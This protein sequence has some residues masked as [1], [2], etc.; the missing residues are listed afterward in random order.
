MLRQYLCA[1]VVAVLVLPGDPLCARSEPGEKSLAPAED[2]AASVLVQALDSR[3]RAVVVDALSRNPAL[4]ALAADARAAFQA[5]P[6]VKALP[7]PTLGVTAFLAP[8][9][10]RV[11]PQRFMVSF[12]QVLPAGGKR[13][14][15]EVASIHR[16]VALSSL[17]EAERLR[18][19]TRLRVSS[20]ELAFLD[21]QQSIVDDLR[22]HLLQHEEIARARYATGADLSQSVIKIQVEI[23]DVDNQLLSIELRRVQLR[24]LIN[25]LRDRPAETP[26]PRFVL[27]PVEVGQLSTETLTRR[28]LVAR[29]EL[30]AADAEISRAEALIELARRVGKPDWRVGAT[31]TFVDRRQ[32][33]AGRLM[34]PPDNGADIFGLQA[35]IVLPIYR[36]S[37][38]SAREEA[39]QRRVAALLRRRAIEAEIRRGVADFSLRL[40]ILWNQVRLVEDLLIVQAEESLDS[41]QAAYI[42]GLL[43]ALDLLD[44]EHVLFDLRIA[45]ARAQADH[46]IVLAEL[47]G[48]VGEALPDSSKE[49]LP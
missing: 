19:V 27:S 48:A 17:L 43:S 26:L 14:A 6:Q 28:A 18:L 46:L 4:S 3:V 29:P 25:E 33:P 9:E 8:P 44:A 2:S 20:H 37:N 1:A 39:R 12:T 22:Q 13:G 5:G 32:D 49:V 7:N 31:Y 47:E 24:E 42:T 45:A 36:R 21:A 35:A 34:P 38:E 10:T 40:P 15:A 41:A 23:T 11:G 16:A 30:V